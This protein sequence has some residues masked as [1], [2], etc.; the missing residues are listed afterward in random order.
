MGCAHF[1]VSR[2]KASKSFE[3][4]AVRVGAESRGIGWDK[5]VKRFPCFAKG[6][7]DVSRIDYMTQC[8]IASYLDFPL[9]F[10]YRK[11][12][13]HTIKGWICGD[14]IRACAFCGKEAEFLCDF[15]IGDGRTC[16][17]PLCKEHK[18]HRA[19]VGLD[20]DYCPHHK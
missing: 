1:K 15:P 14:G 6:R 5:I 9:P 8:E 20:V 17:L 13:G 7:L 18:T 4:D 2:F 3:V 16:D 12:S 10:F 11:K 19:D